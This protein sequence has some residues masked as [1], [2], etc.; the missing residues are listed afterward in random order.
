MDADGS[1]QRQITA[2]SSWSCMHPSWS[3]DGKRLVFSCRSASSPCGMGIASPVGTR[4]PECSRR[5]FTI[6]PFDLNAQPI[7]LGERDG[8]SPEFAP[9]Q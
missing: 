5:I 9:I 7:Q 3:G 6:S 2:G 8:A 1:R 4:M